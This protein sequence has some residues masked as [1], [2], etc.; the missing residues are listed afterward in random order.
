MGGYSQL[1]A[2][3][4]APVEGTSM[5]ES[6]LQDAPVDPVST[7]TATAEAS[8]VAGPDAVEHIPTAMAVPAAEAHTSGLQ[9]PPVAVVVQACPTAAVHV[10]GNLPQEFVCHN[11]GFH[12]TSVV[13]TKPS[14]TAWA[15]CSTV[16]I[17]GLLFCIFP[18]I[19]APLFLVLPG[20]QEKEHRCPYCGVFL[21]RR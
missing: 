19:C 18:I 4:S 2:E 10:W 7:R 11:C 9:Q 16:C 5:D 20:L 17:V 15:A 1:A 6:L 8:Y 21:G 12:G 13:V 3:A 14:P